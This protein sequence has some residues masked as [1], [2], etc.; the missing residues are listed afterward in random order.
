MAYIS[1]G[2]RYTYGV[3]STLSAVSAITGASAGE[4]VFCEENFRLLTYDGQ[5]WM[6]NDFIK[7]TNGSGVTLATG[8]VVVVSTTTAGTVTRIGA[9]GSALVVG[10]VVFGNT[11]GNPV[12]VA[13][14]GIYQVR[15]NAATNAGNYASTSTTLG[16][17]RTNLT[18]SAGIFGIY[19][20]QTAAA[21]LARCLVKS[22]IEYF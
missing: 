22:K 20:E 11:N 8:D 7:L 4:T 16:Q 18:L 12:A 21:G 9:N 15:V 6:C 5:L 3:K 17:A 10:P 2:R 14:S 1:K 13:I 19:V